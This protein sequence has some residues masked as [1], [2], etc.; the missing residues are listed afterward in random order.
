MQARI[1]LFYPYIHFQDDNWL[2]AS[3]LYWDKMGRIVPYSYETVRDSDTVK[4]LANEL[5][6]IEN[7]NPRLAH[8]SGCVFIDRHI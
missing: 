2:K 8:N 5:G 3:A 7:F 4:A 1:A 6:Y